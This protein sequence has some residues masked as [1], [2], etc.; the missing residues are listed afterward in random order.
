MAI[1]PKTREDARMRRKRRV[2]KVVYGTQERPRLNVFRSH[3]HIYAQIILDD[4]GHT[5]AAA[6]SLDPDLKATLERSGDTEAARAVGRVVAQRALAKGVS[7]V[8][9]DR[10]GYLYHGRV[11][12]LAEA[13]REAGLEF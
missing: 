5:I 11:K 10:S 1:R 6:S 3:K 8:T 4:N 12:A 13:A 7:R 9:F 2:R